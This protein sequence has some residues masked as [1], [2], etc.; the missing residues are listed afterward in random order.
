MAKKKGKR[1]ELPAKET[2]P[3]TEARPDAPTT[4]APELKS[5]RAQWLRKL[6][7]AASIPIAT[8]VLWFS[9]HGL[10]KGQQPHK[11]PTGTPLVEQR[12][13]TKEGVYSTFMV[14]AKGAQCASCHQ[15][16]SALAEGHA[17]KTLKAI[18][19]VRKVYS[20]LFGD[21]PTNH[22]FY[23]VEHPKADGISPTAIW[24]TRKHA[25]QFLLPFYAQDPTKADVQRHE[26]VHYFGA[27]PEHIIYE[28]WA[29]VEPYLRNPGIIHEPITEA[30]ALQLANRFSATFLMRAAV[31]SGKASIGRVS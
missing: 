27:A 6:V 30:N 3:R 13:R 29:W 5:P 1:K 7:L 31:L 28:P 24:E 15:D 23:P 18:E 17:K 20:P 9:L 11:L 12:Y 21:I 22:V 2:G 4:E 14:P 8:G 10:R 26:L 19:D 25:V 16:L